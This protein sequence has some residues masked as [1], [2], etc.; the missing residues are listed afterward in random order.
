MQKQELFWSKKKEE[1][2][3]FMS[4]QKTKLQV[5][6]VQIRTPIAQF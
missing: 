6:T 3:I 4:L 2:R 5:S 1:F